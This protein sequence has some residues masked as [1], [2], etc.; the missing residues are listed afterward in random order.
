MRDILS[1]INDHTWIIM[2]AVAAIGASMA[3]FVGV[4]VD[5]LPHMVGLRQNPDKQMNLVRPSS[6]QSCH[7]RVDAI[8]LIPVI[9]WILIKGRCR[10]CGARISWEYP[11]NEVIVGVLSVAVVWKY[12]ASTSSIIALCGLWLMT[13][14][15]WMDLREGWLPGEMTQPF[16][17]IGLL[18]SP[19]DIFFVDR[20]EGLAISFVGA[21]LSFGWLSWRKNKKLMAGGD[22]VLLAGCG[23]W[24][25]INTLPAFLM[26]VSV[27]YL[28]HHILV[29]ILNKK[30][31]PKEAE[32]KE[33]V[34]DGIF[35]P[36]G[37]AIAIVFVFFLLSQSFC[38]KAICF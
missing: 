19:L 26:S 5:R 25:G 36:M 23:G 7:S 8:S 37:P 2:A 1:T 33:G 13:A 29:R 21:I 20:V 38:I 16:L 11:L 22:I 32:I 24:V 14:M 3:S 10:N 27:L 18:A 35:I 34:G 17:V 31:E 6:C 28:I 12:G 9:G 4:L 30:W 15:S